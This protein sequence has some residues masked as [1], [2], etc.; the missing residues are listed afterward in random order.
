MKTTTVMI[1]TFE[2]VEVDIGLTNILGAYEQKDATFNEKEVSTLKTMISNLSENGFLKVYELIEYK[3][4][5][6]DPKFYPNA[7][8]KIFHHGNPK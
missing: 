3:E 1:K 5:F 4:M 8:K 2:E 7:V 6:V